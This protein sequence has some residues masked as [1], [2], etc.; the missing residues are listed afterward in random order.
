MEKE[1]A[2][3]ARFNFTEASIRRQ[4]SAESYKRGQQY[5]RTRA[6]DSLLQ[7]GAM[8]QGEVSGSQI[9]PYYVHLYAEPVGV[10]GATCTCPYDWGGWCKHIVAV[11]L[12]CIHEPE[13][14]VERPTLEEVLSDMDRDQLHGLL[15]KL[16]ERDLALVDSIERE[17]SILRA[18]STQSESHHVSDP[19]PGDTP[20]VERSIRRRVRAILHSLDHIRQ[21]EAYWHVG[22]VVEQLDEV[23]EEAWS[24]IEAGDGRNALDILK[25]VTEE[26]M[27][28]W[29]TLDDSDGEVSGFF[30]DL[31]RAWTEAILTADLTPDGFAGWGTRLKTW[32][33]ALADYGVDGAFAAA[34]AAA[35][36]GWDS[37]PLQ[38]VLKGETLEE[39]V[40]TDDALYSVEGLTTARLSV[41]ERQGRLQEYV[42]LARAGGDNE[43]CVRMLVRLGRSQD[44]VEYGMQHLRAA[45]EAQSLAVVLRDRNEL[46]KALRVAEHGLT[47]AGH[48]A[49]LAIWV[50]D[51]AKDMGDL[52]R[53]VPAAV[54]AV[55]SDPDLA[56]YLVAKDLAGECWPQYRTE[57]LDH[58][59][60]GDSFILEG[61]LEVFLHEGLVADAIALVG[62]KGDDTEVAK[63]V[64]AALESHPGWVIETCR[65]RAE[66]IMNAAK[67]ERYEYA[68]KWL[69]K[70]Q[71]AYRAA[72][73]ED[74]WQSYLEELLVLHRRKY[75]LVPMLRALEGR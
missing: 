58:L 40:S 29:Q 14:I 45:D 49:P 52:T 69:A 4:A 12:T 50:R 22:K 47:L 54:I 1:S 17:L 10:T 21:S 48:I 51:L 5:Y 70:A 43:R 53:A 15:L 46:E 20:V 65:H 57:I 16:A 74:D 56:S 27:A 42:H 11:L 39:G 24:L 37:E 28:G 34:I 32:R 13:K 64:D 8:I 19:G 71:Q 35:D 25:A 63:V 7:R 55:R 23:L 66:R 18:R 75:R 61:R 68:F 26:Y 60:N 38:R 72:G 41:L 6:V 62:R 30:Y 3:S 36:Q 9:S 59:R 67:S 73:R 2:G 33:K 31:G 44:A